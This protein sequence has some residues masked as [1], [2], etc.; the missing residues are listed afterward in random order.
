V[1]VLAVDGEPMVES[2]DICHWLDELQPEPP[3]YPT[4]PADRVRAEEMEQVADAMRVGVFGA[5][6]FFQRIIKPLLIGS[7]GDEALVDTNL[8]EN[9][10]PLLAELESTVPEQ[11]FLF[12]RFNVADVTISGW[13]RQ[14]MCCP[15]AS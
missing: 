2:S 7:Q 5:G 4:E 11:D 10:P 12:G 15:A 6:M 8:G 13:L 3:I 1:P 14:G 9:A